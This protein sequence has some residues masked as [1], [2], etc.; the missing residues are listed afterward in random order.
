MT[1]TP[2]KYERFIGDISALLDESRRA[3]ARRVNAV[4]TATYWEIGRRIVEYEQAGKRRADY[5]EELLER[6]AEDLTTRFGR[7]FSRQNLH[8]MRQFFHDWPPE[9]ILQTLWGC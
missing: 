8:H 2:A 3:A 7:G 9:R 5:G 1:G 6:M 4:L